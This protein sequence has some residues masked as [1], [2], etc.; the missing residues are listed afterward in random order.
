MDVRGKVLQ[1]LNKSKLRNWTKP[2]LMQ[3]FFKCPF[4]VFCDNKVLIALI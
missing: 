1:V 3:I 4:N 2:Y